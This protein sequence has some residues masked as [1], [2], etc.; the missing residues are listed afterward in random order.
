[1]RSLPI[2][3]TLGEPAGIGPE[4]VGLAWRESRVRA[5]SAFYCLGD[6]A[7]LRNRL[8]AAGIDLPLVTIDSPLAAAEAFPAGLP[9]LQL[10]TAVRTGRA[11]QPCVAD[12]GSVLESIER[13]VAA[14]GDGQARAIVTAPVHKETLYDAGFAFPGHTEFLGQLTRDWPGGGQPPVMMLAAEELRVVPVTVHVPLKD[15]PGYLSTGLILHTGRTVAKA[16]ASRFA[17]AAP[18]LAVCGL[19]P[20]A[21]EGGRLGAEEREVIGPAIEALRADGLDVSGPHPG[22]SLFHPAARAKFDVALA[23]YHDQALIPIKTIAFDTAV[24]VTLGLPLVR[25]SPDHGTALA[26]AG[27]G[28]ASPHSFIAALRLADRLSSR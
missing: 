3:V 1:M 9:V 20:H 15:V 24:N 6:A 13:G 2:A 7:F 19:N 26:L 5:L 28:R 25:T 27:T 23:M 17:I 21:G 4:L 16:M 18:R 10:R 12:A 11:G 8:A 22:D 14:V